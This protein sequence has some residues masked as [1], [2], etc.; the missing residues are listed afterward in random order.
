LMNS[1]DPTAHNMPWMYVRPGTGSASAW[2]WTPWAGERVADRCSSWGRCSLQQV[3]EEGVEVK[4]RDY[5]QQ[6]PAMIPTHHLT[7][8]VNLA[9]MI[10][11]NLTVGQKPECMAWEKAVVT[12]LPM[13]KTIL[14]IWANCPK[15]YGELNE[16]ILVLVKKF[17]VFLKVLH[18]KKLV[19]SPTKMLQDYFVEE[20]Q[21]LWAKVV[22]LDKNNQKTV[23]KCGVDSV[24]WGL[25]SQGGIIG[26]W[27]EEVSKVSD[28]SICI[29]DNFVSRKV[30]KVSLF[31]RRRRRSP[32]IFPLN[33]FHNS[34][35]NE[36]KNGC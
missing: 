27:L 25:D 29:A 26:E 10:S 17:G 18:L 19:L 15:T 3:G 30:L 31:R 14:D 24:G 33:K 23:V 20:G 22:E 28:W 34:E 6:V 13:K 4:V 11:S 5:G 2:F 8:Q 21:T 35:K 16:G 12:I 32:Q 36:N 9:T 1:S 7:N